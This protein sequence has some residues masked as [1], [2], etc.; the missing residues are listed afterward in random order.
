MSEDPDSGR[1]SVARV[2]A[3]SRRITTDR[4]FCDA[5]ERLHGAVPTVIG[6]GHHAVLDQDDQHRDGE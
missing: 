5:L 1:R 2:A 3:S 6:T 4:A